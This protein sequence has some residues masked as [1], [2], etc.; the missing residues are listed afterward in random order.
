M[1]FSPSSCYL[2]S[3]GTKYS[4]QRPVLRHFQFIRMHVSKQKN[5]LQQWTIFQEMEVNPHSCCSQLGSRCMITE[6]M[7]PMNYVRENTLPCDAVLR[8]ED[9][10]VFGVHRSILSECSTYF[11]FVWLLMWLINV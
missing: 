8:L 6:E 1:Q 10:H 11:R 9:G 7:L 5:L 4:S 2:L 3:R